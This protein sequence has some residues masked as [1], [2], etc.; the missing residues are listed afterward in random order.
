MYDIQIEQFAVSGYRITYPSETPTHKSRYELKSGIFVGPEFPYYLEKINKH[1]APS[2][3]FKVYDLMFKPTESLNTTQY[4]KWA[5]AYEAVKTMCAIL[6]MPCLSASVF[7]V[8]LQDAKR[9]YP[10]YLE[11][12]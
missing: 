1:G 6:N 11:E 4:V 3:C 2:D 5:N 10:R 12:L 8:Q 7:R 9:H